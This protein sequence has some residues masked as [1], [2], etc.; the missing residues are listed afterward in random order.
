MEIR[1]NPRLISWLVLTILF[2]PLLACNRENGSV[3]EKTTEPNATDASAV[4]TIRKAALGQTAPAF[5][6]KNQEGN[7][8]SLSA[9]K[10]KFVVLEWTNTDCPFVK[11]HYS[12]GT[13]IGIA[14]D[15]MHKDVVWMAIN[16][17]HWATASSNR[18]WHEQYQLSYPI[19][20][21]SAG[22]VGRLYGAKTTPHMFIINKEG[23]LVYSGGID[24]DD[25]GSLG[26]KRI[27]YVRS[28]LEDLVAGN[29]PQTRQSKPY[30]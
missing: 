8:V 16:S 15:F 18:K 11:R 26:D 1:M 27:H 19:L 6:L 25:A 2:L 9:F 28:A 29:T 24:N 21:D 22:K 12:E 17:T 7:P 5:T 30:G 20:D 10:G 14:R 13:F 23:L 3:S 4:K